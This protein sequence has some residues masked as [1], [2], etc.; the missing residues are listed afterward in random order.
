LDVSKTIFCYSLYLGLCLAGL[1]QLGSYTN[2]LLDL[3]TQDPA[4]R[5]ALREILPLIVLA[6]PLNALVFAADGVLQ[7][8]AEFPF[9]ARAMILSGLTAI[10][11]FIALEHMMGPTTSTAATTGTLVHVWWA[12]IALQ[13]MRGFTS[14]WKLVDAKGPI[15]LLSIKQTL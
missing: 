12:L 14:F 5:G 9:Q 3:F 2:W 8:A 1:L 15:N 13:L 7:G 6:Q 11:T 4:T 10:G